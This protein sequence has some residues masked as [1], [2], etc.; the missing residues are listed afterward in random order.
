M[1][2]ALNDALSQRYTYEVELTKKRVLSEKLLTYNNGKKVCLVERENNDIIR[3]TLSKNT[4]NI[5][6]KD[7]SSFI[8]T[9]IQYG[10]PEVQKFIPIFAN[11]I[12]NVTY[13]STLNAQLVDYVASY[14]Y[15][16]PDIHKKVVKQL[17]FFDTGIENVEIKKGVDV[18]GNEQYLSEFTHKT[19]SGNKVLNYFDQSMGTKLLYNQLK[20]FFLILSN[21]GIFIYDELGEHLHRRIV[22]YL[23]GFFWDEER[24]TNH[25]QLIFTTHYS[26]VMDDMKK[27][28][29]YLFNKEEGES[30]CYRV[31]ELSS[32][33]SPRNDR[34]LENMYKTGMLGGVPNV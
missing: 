18:F 32:A 3:N 8:S 19:E 14:Y 10:V 27:Y 30:Y 26:Q 17:R 16:N 1:V 31:D 25:A 28:R 13:N 12:T 9:F 33:V 21:G 34:S 20:D 5:I 29:T 7:N 11:A 23:Y 4:D 6:L 15:S 22:P 24:N 2:F